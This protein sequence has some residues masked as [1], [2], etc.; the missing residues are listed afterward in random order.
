M[1]VLKWWARAVLLIS[2]S[3]LAQGGSG[4]LSA[5]A[6][7]PEASTSV[8]LTLHYEVGV[9]AG[10]PTRKE[11]VTWQLNGPLVVGGRTIPYESLSS[12]VQQLVG[13]RSPVLHVDVHQA[14]HPDPTCELNLQGTL[15]S[16]RQG[17]VVKDLR[18][19]VSWETL[20]HGCDAATARRLY[21]AGVEYRNL[22]IESLD[23]MGL[24]ELPQGGGERA[25]QDGS[26]AQERSCSVESLPRTSPDADRYRCR[27][28]QEVELRLTRN[29]YG[30][31][32]Y[33]GDQSLDRALAR[34]CGER[35]E[36]GDGPGASNEQERAEEPSQQQQ[37]QQQQQ[38]QQRQEQ[39]VYSPTEQGGSGLGQGLGG[40]GSV[41]GGLA[42]AALKDDSEIKPKEVVLLR[43]EVRSGKNYWQPPVTSLALISAGVLTYFA[44]EGL[45]HLN[46]HSQRMSDLEQPSSFGPW[47]WA[48]GVD[49]PAT[50]W[51]RPEFHFL[52]GYQGFSYKGY[53]LD[54]V[55][56]GGRDAGIPLE[57]G[58]GG[59]FVGLTGRWGLLRG[60]ASYLGAYGDLLA[61]KDE[62]VATRLVWN[63]SGDFS[64]TQMHGFS[65]ADWSLGLQL[66]QGLLSPYA[67][68][69]TTSL[70]PLH[71]MNALF[72]SDSSTYQL[73]EGVVL[74]PASG[75]IY[76]GNTFNFSGLFATT[77]PLRRSL[78]V[79]VSVPLVA[80]APVTT[81]LRVGLGYVATWY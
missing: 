20:F 41:G 63:P 70:F 5:S 66:W 47:A 61:G 33:N 11:Y 53:Y 50:W 22:R 18:S 72:V 16:D 6:P 31:L 55:A 1:N 42:A 71:R 12:P 21:E 48:F 15:I 67:E 60:S 27:S 24:D 35:A 80:F 68:Y 52:T 29:A 30:V 39:I 59:H 54:S 56:L 62:I 78:I 44:L 43:E 25:G 7:W 3:A 51:G 77:G 75:A 19:A 13:P 10:E 8:T 4:S 74:L 36:G 64:R 28:C 17:K 73:D 79:D 45:N 37:Q 58:L 26:P 32:S 76:V 65:G 14:G 38:R 49:G 23:F 2:T 9:W 81:T 57:T 46:R 40:V 34:A 69:R